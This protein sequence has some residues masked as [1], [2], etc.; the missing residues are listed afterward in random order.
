MFLASN[1]SSM[2]RHPSTIRIVKGWPINRDSFRFP[3]CLSWSTGAQPP[4]M[5]FAHTWRLAVPHPA[6]A[7]LSSPISNFFI[8]RKA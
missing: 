7:R 5:V 3:A 6:A 4:Q 2:T 1:C 8:L